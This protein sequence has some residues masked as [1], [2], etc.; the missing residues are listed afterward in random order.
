VAIRRNA[1]LQNSL[2]SSSQNYSLTITQSAWHNLSHQDMP[3]AT[4]RTNLGSSEF[5][6]GYTSWVRSMWILNAPSKQHRWQ[7]PHVSHVDLHNMPTD[8]A[9]QSC[10]TLECKYMQHYQDIC[11]MAR[12]AFER[13][14]RHTEYSETETATNNY[15]FLCH[16]WH[17]YSISLITSGWLIILWAMLH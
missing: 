11:N 5:C 15:L 1:Q 13:W 9:F 3:T 14:Q 17:H 7:L 4:V 10:L 8:K 6:V 2:I 16:C 12:K